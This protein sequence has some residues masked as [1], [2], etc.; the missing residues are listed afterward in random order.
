MKKLHLISRKI[1]KCLGMKRYFTGLPCPY[2]H[3]SERYVHG[4]NCISCEK[5]NQKTPK[6]AAYLKA[7][8][9]ENWL[10]LKEYRKS[11]KN[12]N[13]DKKA[14]GDKEWKQRNPGAVYA[15]N[16]RRQIA[17]INRS[18]K[19]D[20]HLTDF[21]FAEANS[22]AKLRTKLTGVKWQVD[23]IIPLLG[24]EVSG[25]H[26]WNNFEVIPAYINL[27]KNANF[28]YTEPYTWRYFT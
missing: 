1:A 18:P 28:W 3:Y 12:E 4:Y 6:R 17:K 2:G 9:E 13:F 23:H 7:Y 19:W 27:R 11:W 14:A 16:R 15:S 10:T 25:L 24:S 21:V 5:I 20:T 22:L 26:V 8:A